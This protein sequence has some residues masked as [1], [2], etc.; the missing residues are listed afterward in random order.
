[1]RPCA[2]LSPPP[3]RQLLGP[4]WGLMG[5][6]DGFGAGRRGAFLGLASFLLSANM[7]LGFQLELLEELGSA[8]FPLLSTASLHRVRLFKKLW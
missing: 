4:R 1:M 3:P 2:R 6:G 8:L 7:S 5:P